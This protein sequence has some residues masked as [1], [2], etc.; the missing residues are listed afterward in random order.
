MRQSGQKRSQKTAEK[1]KDTRAAGSKQSERDS[2]KGPAKKASKK[3]A[4]A[5]AD[6][7]RHCSK[8]LVKSDRA[9][10]VE[11]EV[12]RIFCSE[13]CIAEY[14]SPEINRLEKE[15][16]RFL[17]PSDLSGEEREKLA[18]LRWI[19]LQEPD[20]VWREKTL[21]GDYRYTLISEF[22]PAEKPIWCICMTLFLRGEPSFMFIAFATKN[23]SMVNHYRRGEQI[24]PQSLKKDAEASQESSTGSE[25]SSAV[26]STGQVIDGLA[27]AWTE[28]ES[29]RAQN[30]QSRGADDIQLEKFERYEEC[31]NE[32]LEAPDEVW[33]LDPD[34]E[35][36]L[37]TFHFIKRYSGARESYWFV[38][39]ARETEDPEEIEI[40]DL[41]PTRDTGLVERYRRGAL[42]VG[43]PEFPAQSRLVH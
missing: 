21:T 12:G 3:S 6:A 35:D 15:F 37:R 24:D 11:E 33:G 2:A 19:T 25:E 4:V 23:A 14:F 9:L 1:S 41:F 38:I 22:K 39:V 42:E 17:S 28:E 26:N 30:V 5:A 40:L 34:G 10:F 27:D 16:Q 20:E 7:C 18:H 43:I 29:R 31:M 13:S 8:D 32:T 36:E